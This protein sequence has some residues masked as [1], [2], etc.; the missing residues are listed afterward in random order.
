MQQKTL[1]LAKIHPKICWKG[2]VK[3]QLSTIENR[4]FL[5]R[6]IIQET[7]NHLLANLHENCIGN[8]PSVAPTQKCIIGHTS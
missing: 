4:H 8:I 2:S 6:Q 5:E 3:T 7:F 1:L